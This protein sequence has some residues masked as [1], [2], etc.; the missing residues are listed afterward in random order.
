M[1]ST[2]PLRN[3][4]STDGPVA[5]P[6]PRKTMRSNGTLFRTFGGICDDNNWS[7]SKERHKR[8]KTE[9]EKGRE[10]DRNLDT[11]C[12][13]KLGEGRGTQLNGFQV[14]EWTGYPDHAANFADAWW[15]SV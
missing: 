15:S 7:H 10:T 5:L 12:N 2:T 13:A 9:A 4:R 1:L 8:H 3:S 11:M 6:T 14:D